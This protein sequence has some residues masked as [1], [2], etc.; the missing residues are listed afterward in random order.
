MNL[1]VEVDVFHDTMISNKPSPATFTPTP[2]SKHPGMSIP[3]SLG[4]SLHANRDKH[5]GAVSAPKPR[6]SSDEV[7]AEKAKK[8]QEKHD[9]ASKKAVGLKNV[10]HLK[11]RMQKEDDKMA[12]QANHPPVNLEKRELRLRK[13]V[14]GPK[15]KYFKSF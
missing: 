5:P 14:P 15:R 6:R 9:K 1:K 11:D 8:E 2:M 12:Q 13:E 3:P 10:A 4:M 7:A